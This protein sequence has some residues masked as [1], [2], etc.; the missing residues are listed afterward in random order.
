MNSVYLK[1]E[2]STEK[3]GR[4]LGNATRPEGAEDNLFR[5]TRGARIF[6]SGDLGAGK[7]TL[8]RGVL[9]E[10]GYAGAVKSPTYTLVEPYEEQDY[11]LYHF[12]LYRL[13]DPEE[14]EFLGVLD[15]FGDA[16]LCLIEWAEKGKGYLPRPDIEITLTV[17]GEGRRARWEP[18]S[19]KGAV[20]AHRLSGLAE[21]IKSGTGRQ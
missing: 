6:L 21:S 8:T 12:D 19:A 17:E 16:N 10:F 11:N 15:Y 4:M 5:S 1:N 9:R 18:R 2:S 20:I 7:T 13:S 3:L 14:V